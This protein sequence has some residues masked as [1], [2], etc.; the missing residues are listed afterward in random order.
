[1]Q[2]CLVGRFK[3]EITIRID[4]FLNY[5]MRHCVIKKI[6]LPQHDDFDKFESY[7][8]FLI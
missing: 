3:K 6:I 2:F 4:D 5:N 1:M 7:K 8:V